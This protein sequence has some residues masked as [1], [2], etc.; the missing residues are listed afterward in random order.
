MSAGSGL[1]TLL[2]HINPVHLFRPASGERSLLSQL[3]LYVFVTLI[4]IVISMSYILFTSMQL[5]KIVDEQFQSER[6]YQQLQ[7]E[8][9]Q[10]QDP[11]RSYL[12]T[13]SSSALA[14]L[15]IREQTLRE[16]TAEEIPAS[17]DP[18]ELKKREVFMLIHSY[19]DLVDEAIGQ[20]RSRSI[21]EYTRLYEL[22]GDMNSY[23]IERID[24]ISLNGFRV[25]I[26][27]Y[28]QIITISRQLQFWNLM[29]IIFAFLW[30]ITWMMFSLDKAT[31]PM[32]E[33]SLMARELAVGNFEVEDIHIDSVSEVSSVV[34]AFNQMKYDMQQYI[35]EIKHQK[36]IE[37]DYLQEKLRNLKMEQLLKRMELYTM[38]AQMNPHFLFN[39]LNT[40][41]QLAILED[42]DKT[43]EYME[44]LALFFRH[45][46]RERKLFVPL[47]H[48]IEGLKSYFY[49]LQIRF[50]KSLQISLDL[51]EGIEQAV[52]LCRDQPCMIPAMIL[53]PLVENSVVHAFKGVDHMGEIRV[54][55]WEEDSHI[56]LSVKDNGAGIPEQTLQ[57]LLQHAERASK[58]GSKIMGLENVIQRLYFFYPENEQVITIDSA[59]GTGTEVLITIDK[60]EAPCITL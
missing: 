28:G 26:V 25:Q 1:H 32:H 59:P 41:V 6:F 48:E 20:K 37:Q 13:R 43:A 5:Q 50:P 24:E 55:V 33:L 42:A 21:S 14:S 4:V 57:T 35:G 7:Q 29:V 3:F 45:N 8:L 46:M 39:T 23:I 56:C 16:M 34:E 38:Q 40:G 15:L 58:E 18:E 12:S 9:Q 10:L 60:R 44:N 47:M 54:R 49:I 51:E 19:L 36:A 11:F 17:M 53:Q 27:E 22:M 31:K 30:A 52:D 2:E